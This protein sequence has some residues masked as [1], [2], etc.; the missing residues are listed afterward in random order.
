MR[1]SSGPAARLRLA[2]ELYEAAERIKLQSLRRRHPDE[3]EEQIERRL[4]RWIAKR[5]EV[6]EGPWELRLDPPA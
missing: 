6:L 5:D 3:T 1:E 4:H 2:L